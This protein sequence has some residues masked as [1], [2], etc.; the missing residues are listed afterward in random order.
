MSI[1]SLYVDKGRLRAFIKEKKPSLKKAG[2][3]LSLSRNQLT[4]MTRLLT[5]HS[6][7]RM[8]M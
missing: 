4:I 7:K 1:D 3:F 8:P 5:G 2:E 6:F